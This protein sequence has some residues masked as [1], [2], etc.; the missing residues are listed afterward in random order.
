LVEHRVD[1]NHAGRVWLFD[2]EWH[3]DTPRP[4]RGKKDGTFQV[5]L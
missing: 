1:L 3:M 2:W 4:A 5:G